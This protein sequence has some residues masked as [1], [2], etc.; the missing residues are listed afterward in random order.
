MATRAE[1]LREIRQLRSTAELQFSRIDKAIQRRQLPASASG[2][3]FYDIVKYQRREANRAESALYAPLRGKG[4]NNK[5]LG[6]YVASLRKLTEQRTATVSGVRESLREDEE[7]ANFVLNFYA[8]MDEDEIKSMTRYQKSKFFQLATLMMEELEYDSDTAFSA[9][10]HIMSTS[11][12]KAGA[13]FREYT[14][15]AERFLGK[16]EV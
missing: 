9:V 3:Y 15:D 8:D 12:K 16:Y 2:T 6:E 10:A 13:L 11:G 4:I 14:K 5:V 7:N 1:L